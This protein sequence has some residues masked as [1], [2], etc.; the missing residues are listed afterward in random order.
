MD[1]NDYWQENKRFVMTVASGLVVFAIGSQIIG[2]TIG[3]D[4]KQERG[5]LARKTTEYR[6][7]RYL[8][9]DL[10]LAREENAKLEGVVAE[11]AGRV[12]FVPRPEFVLDPARGS[13]GIQYF[14]EVS[15][16][17]EGL[18]RRANRNNVRIVPDLGLP[19]LA[20]TRDD[21]IER[22][23][24]ALDVIDRVLNFAVD[25][26]VS[27]VEKIAIRLD[28][29]LRSRKGI[30]RVEKTKVTMKMSGPSGPILRLIAATQAPSNGA[31]IIVD[32]LTMVPE[33]L[34]TDEAKL[35]IT[36][37]VPRLSLVDSE[38][39]ENFEADL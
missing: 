39:T 23:L 22:H 13:A 9:S 31:S 21:E 33:R 4:L 16:V 37:L 2:S 27:R 34:K 14:D 38:N 29:G 32:S 30:G 19:A 26:G 1:L 36:F 28:P 10:T 8:P 25:E 24:E 6:K 3:A 20:P 17:R 11:L 5:S 12:G 7:S 15:R 18:L 35:E